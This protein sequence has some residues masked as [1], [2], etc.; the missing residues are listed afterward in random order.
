M[1]NY[2][3][4]LTIIYNRSIFEGVFPDDMK[5]AKVIPLHKG[6]SPLTVSNYRPISLLLIFSK[7]FERLIFDRLN[8]FV[9]ENKLLTQNQF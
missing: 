4:L 1:S 6:K 7:I 9:I 8:D 5:V 3:Q 2:H